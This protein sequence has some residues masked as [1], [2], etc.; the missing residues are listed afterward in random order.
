VNG[1]T[2][3]LARVA[4]LLD[5]VRSRGSGCLCIVPWHPIF[6]STVSPV[7]V[8]NERNSRR[9]GEALEW[10]AERRPA[11]VMSRRYYLMVERG[12]ISEAQADRIMKVLSESYRL[13]SAGSAGFWLLD[14]RRRS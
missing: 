9:W 7:Y 10:A 14:T 11:A 2:Y 13:H 8:S 6:I 1:H 5:A 4:W 12:T 3:P